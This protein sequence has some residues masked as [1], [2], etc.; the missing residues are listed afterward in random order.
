MSIS[1]LFSVPLWATPFLT[2]QGVCPAKR[3]HPLRDM[4]PFPDPG[5]QVSV[6]H[7]YL[8]G[9]C[10]PLPQLCPLSDELPCWCAYPRLVEWLSND[11]GFEA[12]VC[13]QVRHGFT[14]IAWVVILN[15][16]THSFCVYFGHHSRL[17]II[18][19]ILQD[20]SYVFLFIWHVLTQWT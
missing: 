8:R 3:T 14:T 12:F 15:Q 11:C 19:L 7:V 10:R 9:L 13:E 4:L 1:G 16:D 20:S 18:A 6:V 17:H 5:S 2:W